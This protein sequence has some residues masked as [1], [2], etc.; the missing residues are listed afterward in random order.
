VPSRSRRRI[1]SLGSLRHAP[2]R[3]RRGN[4]ADVSSAKPS[5]SPSAPNPSVALV[6]MESAT[7]ARSS[8]S[9][10]GDLHP[11]RSPLPSGLSRDRL[12]RTVVRTRCPCPPPCR[13]ELP[14]RQP[15]PEKKPES[16]PV[17]QDVKA[18]S[19]WVPGSPFAPCRAR[20]R[21]LQSPF[22]FSFFFF[23]I[24]ISPATGNKQG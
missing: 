14:A 20:S 4:V 12:S 19:C 8:P 9:A 21:S 2:S 5:Q 13:Q 18:A 15:P 16:L 3:K 10:D 24:F 23:F 1:S 17:P 7:P 6:Q 11:K 22:A